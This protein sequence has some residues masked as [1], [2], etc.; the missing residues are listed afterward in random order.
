MTEQEYFKIR[1]DLILNQIELLEST[2]GKIKDYIEELKDTTSWDI[3]KDVRI[4]I[5]NQINAIMSVNIMNMCFNVQYVNNHSFQVQHF[6]TET[7]KDADMMFIAYLTMNKN[8]FVYNL[9]AIIERYLRIVILEFDSTIDITKG[10]Y[11]IKKKLFSFL[12]ISKD[13]D[14]WNGLKLLSSIRNTIHNNGI[15]L[16]KNDEEILYRESVHPF[17]NNRPHISASYNNLNNIIT[18]LLSLIKM[19]NNFPLIKS[20]DIFIDYSTN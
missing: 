12:G 10:I 1:S 17:I 8:G 9:S 7:F 20:K 18:D 16:S 5:L 2:R 13:S 15:H 19:I 4:N 3:D 11:S 6:K 14:E